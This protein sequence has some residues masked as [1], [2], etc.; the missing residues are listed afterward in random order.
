MDLKHQAAHPVDAAVELKKSNALR[1]RIRGLSYG[2]IAEDIGVSKSMAHAYVVEALDELRALNA[3]SASQLRELELSR[4]DVQREKLWDGESA[5]EPDVN[6]SLIRI[7]E[8]RAR[9]A[10]LDVPVDW[11]MGGLPGAVPIP[12]SSEIDLNK[13]S[14][15]QLREL[16]TLLA[17]ADAAPPST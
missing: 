13:L 6:N 7:A 16:H 11:R 2:R 9:L 5:L 15:D 12:I 10:G 1:L 14:L 17:A 3:E 4:L 8:R